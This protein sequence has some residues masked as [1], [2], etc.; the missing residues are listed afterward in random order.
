MI[1]RVNVLKTE[2]VQVRKRVRKLKKKSTTHDG[3]YSIVIQR[4]NRGEGVK[5]VGL[6]TLVIERGQL[7]IDP[8]EGRL[9]TGNLSLLR[10]LNGRVTESGKITGK[11]K[12]DLLFGKE[13]VQ[14]VRF[15][16]AIDPFK[17]RGKWDDYFDL[18]IE[19]APEPS[20][21]AGRN[22]DQL[23]MGRALANPGDI[24]VDFETITPDSSCMNR[25]RGLPKPLNRMPDVMSYN[26]KTDEEYQAERQKENLLYEMRSALIS[27]GTGCLYGSKNGTLSNCENIIEWV[28]RVVEKDAFKPLGFKKWPMSA[29]DIPLED[30]SPMMFFYVIAFDMTNAYA[31]ATKA[32]PTS[33]QSKAAFIEWMEKRLDLYRDF[34]GLRITTGWSLHGHENIF[35]ALTLARLALYAFSGDAEKFWPEL[36][37]WKITLA[38]MR[39]DGSLPGETRRGA[40]ALYYEARALQGLIKLAKMADIQGI[41]LHALPING[42]KSFEKAMAFYLT[43]LGNHDLVIG[44]AKENI[45]GG[46]ENDPIW[47]NWREQHLRAL[48]L[49]T[50]F[51]EYLSVRLADTDLDFDPR[52]IKLDDRTCSNHSKKRPAVCK[53]N[54]KDLTLSDLRSRSRVGTLGWMGDLCF[55]PVE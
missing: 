45:G 29:K 42:G 8:H 33:N 43:A 16:G 36:S 11:I 26:A 10:T 22:W 21:I 34:L 15:K 18:I 25:S 39:P 20:S 55:Y 32:I 9:E 7:T 40:R 14:N 1:G 54:E 53:K 2:Q 23:P 41:D 30:G 47:A 48:H 49:E 5:Q 51:L 28:E 17:I 35:I 19:L 37:Q 46:Y 24:L 50:G 6:A 12:I 27:S 3:K 44:Y 31:L 13:G 52:N 4:Y 38:S